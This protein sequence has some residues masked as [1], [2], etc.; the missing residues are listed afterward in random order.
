MKPYGVEVR[1]SGSLTASTQDIPGVGDAATVMSDAFANASPID[2]KAKVYQLGPRTVVALVSAKAE[3][4]M[5]QLDA[6][7]SAVFERVTSRKQRELFSAWL[8]KLMDKADIEVNDSV[9]GG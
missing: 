3:P 8:K 7:R 2:G 4:D 6:E 5:N 9:V 1:S